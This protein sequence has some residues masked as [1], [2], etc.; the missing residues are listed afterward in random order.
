ME[1]YPSRGETFMHIASLLQGES[2]G[3]GKKGKKR[4]SP[5]QLKRWKQKAMDLLKANQPA[6]PQQNPI[7]PPPE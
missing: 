4:R 3:K 6:Q 2:K 7:C 5:K 1:L